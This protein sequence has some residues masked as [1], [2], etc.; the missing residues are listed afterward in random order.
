MPSVLLYR[1]PAGFR[2]L[3]LVTLIA[4]SMSTFDMTM[5][6]AAA[7]FTNDIYR[8]FLRPQAR[9]RELLTATYLFCG[10]TVSLAFLLAYNI[11]NINTIWGWITMG[12]WSGIGMPLL[13]R[14]Y[15]WRFNGA[16]YAA[17]IFGGLA[18][19]LGVLALDVVWHVQF[20]EVAQF[21]IIT[22]I[23]LICA[24]VGTYL[25]RPTEREALEN[26]YRQ[27]RPFGFWAPL[28]RVLPDRVRDAMRIEHRNDLLALPCA[29]VWMVTMYLLPMQ[30]IIKQ[31][32]A[33]GATLVLFV[34]SVAGLYRFWYKNLPPGSVV[35][36]T[37]EASE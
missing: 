20:S 5:N 19:A 10:V 7:M 1:I 37:E 16:G 9:N 12:L 29:F 31:Y 17:S 23:S 35:T 6:K 11:R 8:R 27:T 18:A 33:F 30:L 21:L 4:A 32:T 36:R 26:F 25:G 3:I 14:F 34:L 2:G 28:A 15:W 24:V 13:L 22:P